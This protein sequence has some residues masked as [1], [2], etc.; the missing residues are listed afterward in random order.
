MATERPAEGQPAPVF[1]LSTHT[2]DTP[3][4]LSDFAGR[5]VVL[6]FYPAD[7]TPGCTTESCA[8]RDLS[9]E[10]DA[11][12][13]VILGISPDDV[14]SHRAFA[15]KYKLPFPLLADPDHAVAESYGAWKEKNNYGRKYMGIERTTF[16]IGKDGNIAK[17]FGRVRVDGHGD[18]VLN[19]VKGIV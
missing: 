14:A 13:A 5:I 4:S 8:F 16:V 7:D 18:A 3:V 11:A 15:E 10:Y 12:G 1:S 17:V 2:S 19:F 9:A 6:Y